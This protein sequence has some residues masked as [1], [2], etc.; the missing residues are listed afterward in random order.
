MPTTTHPKPT[1]G[2]ASSGRPQ[3]VE[4]RHPK[5]KKTGSRY[6]DSAI[7]FELKLAGMTRQEWLK[8]LIETQADFARKVTKS[9][10]TRAKHLH[11]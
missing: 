3:H 5:V 7:E 4:P 2:T 1:K 10:K 8:G 11:K 9:Y 6:M